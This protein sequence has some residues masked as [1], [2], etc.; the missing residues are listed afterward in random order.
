MLRVLVCPQGG[1]VRGEGVGLACMAKGGQG[2][3]MTR[4]MGMHGRGSACRR[5]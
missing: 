5:D 3:C 1:D 4:G 2:A